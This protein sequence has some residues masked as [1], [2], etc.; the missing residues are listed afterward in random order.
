[1]SK[2]Q[3]Q[4][5]SAHAAIR[6]DPSPLCPNPFCSNLSLKFR[7]WLFFSTSRSQTRPSQGKWGCN[8]SLRKQ[9]PPPEGNAVQ[10]RVCWWPGDEAQGPVLA[11]VPAAPGRQAE[12]SACTC[13]HSLSQEQLRVRLSWA[14]PGAGLLSLQGRHGPWEAAEWRGMGLSSPLP[15]C[16]GLQVW[17]GTLVQSKPD[18]TRP[19]GGLLRR[20]YKVWTRNTGIVFSAPPGTQEPC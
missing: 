13:L 12:S 1:M 8:S 20:K 16:M 9:R 14:H 7:T 17:G 18:N 15:S 5:K 2:P 19:R 11:Q 3:V 10:T 6:S 4:A